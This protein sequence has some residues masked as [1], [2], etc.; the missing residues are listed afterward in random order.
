MEMTCFQV[1]GCGTALA[2][3]PTVRVCGYLVMLL[4]AVFS[5]ACG[6]TWPTVRPVIDGRFASAQVASVDVLPVDVQVTSYEGDGAEQAGAS[7]ED[8][9]FTEAEGHVVS[10]LA[11]RGYHVNAM[12]DWAGKGSLADGRRV[13]VLPRKALEHTVGALSAYGVA[14]SQ[15]HDGV[16]L[17]PYLP[18][19]LGEATGSDATLYVG[20]YSYKG[21][22]G[23][24]A[25]KVIGTIFV[26]IFIVVVIVVVA[27]V[28]KKGGSSVGRAAGNAVSA[29]GRAAGTVGRVVVFGAARLGTALEPILRVG[30]EIADV[31]GRTH[32]G[33]H[34][35]V[36]AASP[37]ARPRLPHGGPSETL[38]EMTLVDNRTGLVLWH[39]RDRF[40]ASP[41]RSGDVREVFSRLLETLPSRW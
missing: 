5:G 6:R 36:Y 28:A 18:A 16:P 35:G 10:L 17:V 4:A 20:G 24:S 22:D 31:Y 12:V 34:L 41:G 2:F 7:L 32:A 21:H 19:R 1:L 14:Q 23:P 30:L 37:G 11:A 33:T 25:G 9:F 15:R 3:R 39:A 29:V 13:R 27:A 38:L 8:R 26:V 40:P